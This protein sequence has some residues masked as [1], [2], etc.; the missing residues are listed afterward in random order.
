MNRLEL[1]MVPPD[2]NSTPSE[3]GNIPEEE[4]NISGKNA[5]TKMIDQ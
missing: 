1:A 3:E 5:G 2:L 4:V